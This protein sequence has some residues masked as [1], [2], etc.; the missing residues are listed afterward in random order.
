MI[1]KEEPESSYLMS[2]T[3]SNSKKI[4]S[5]SNQVKNSNLYL[6]DIYSIQEYEREQN[7][8]ELTN[9]TLRRNLKNSPSG[10]KQN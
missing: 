10:I 4:T 3:P 1:F 8:D 9:K 5:K 2:L 7:P 6:S